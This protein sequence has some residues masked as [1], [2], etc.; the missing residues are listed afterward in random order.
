MLSLLEL[1]MT[2]QINHRKTRKNIKEKH[3]ISNSKNQALHKSTND[4]IN[5]NHRQISVT[6]TY[7]FNSKPCNVIQ[8]E[9]KQSL[10]FVIVQKIC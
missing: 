1:L 3:E 5:I 2:Q 9:K 8:S 10:S 4:P 6:G 7:D